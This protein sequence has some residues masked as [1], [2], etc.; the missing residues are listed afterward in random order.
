[1]HLPAQTMTDAP[2]YGQKAAPLDTDR[3][4]LIPS[5]RETQ[6][7]VILIAIF[8][9]L[10]LPKFLGHWAA[11][12]AAVYVAGHMI[13]TGQEALVYAASPG[14]FGDT[15]ELW[16][17]L[18]RELG[19]AGQYAFPYIYPPIWAELLA[20]LTKILTPQQFF[21]LFGV[22]HCAALA[23]SVWL[24]AKVARPRTMSLLAFLMIALT[25]G[26][27]TTPVQAAALFNQ[28][29][30]ITTFLTLLM[31]ERLQAG[32]P[33]SAGVALAFAAAIKL[34]PALFILV[35]LLD[36]NW[37]ALKAFAL[38][39]LALAL[40]C[41][42]LSPRLSL[43]FLALM[44]EVSA[45]STIARVNAS[46]LPA[47]AALAAAAGW[48]PAIEMQGNAFLLGPDVYALPMWITLLPKF[49]L[50]LC[51]LATW[52]IMAPAAPE[53]RRTGAALLIALIL[54]LFG[55]LGWL[56]Y[57]VLPLLLLPMLAPALPRVVAVIGLITLT[58]VNA[59]EMAVMVPAL[60]ANIPV[61]VMVTTGSW[62][63]T[64]VIAMIAL[65]KF[66]RPTRG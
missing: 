63:A 28:P 19:G 3:D 36:R 61:H 31:L 47:L 56:H 33:V 13:A 21:N 43:E 23:G 24:A 66:V 14:F 52:R 20:P 9:M 64:L 38:A 44:P 12:L 7:G 39:G 25:V 53:L 45:H 46:L 62:L 54:P 1:M 11:D 50:M 6:I 48:V 8:T 4:A 41:F 5:R 10:L 60:H 30:L 40:I 34:T 18:V 16:K 22:I 65:A 26:Y 55:P 57:Y 32:R 17:P 29:T 42:A 2:A 35:F 51:V 49:L 59:P 27:L 58:I 15:P 37:R